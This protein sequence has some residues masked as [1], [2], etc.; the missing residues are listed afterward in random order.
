MHQIE[1]N[2]LLEQQLGGLDIFLPYVKDYV[3][4]FIGKSI[5]TLQWKEHLYAYWSV[6]G[7]KEKVEVLDQVDWNAWLYGEGQILPVNIEYDLTLAEKAYTLAEKW[8][9]VRD[10]DIS[11]LSFKATDLDGFNSNQT[12]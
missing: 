2:I 4:T 5:T 1:Y 7:G 12:G 8:D 10:E 9:M 3:K 11:H 6:Y